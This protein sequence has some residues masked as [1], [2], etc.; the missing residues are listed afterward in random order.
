VL[1]HVVLVELVARAL[2]QWYLTV[3]VDLV[4]EV[5]S[6][7][8]PAYADSFDQFITCGRNGSEAGCSGIGR[9]TTKLG[10]EHLALIIDLQKKLRTRMH[11]AE[12]KSQRQLRLKKRDFWGGLYLLLGLEEPL[13]GTHAVDIFLRS[14][15]ALEYQVREIM[16]PQLCSPL[17]RV[18][19][20]VLN[21]GRSAGTTQAIKQWLAEKF[22]QAAPSFENLFLSVKFTLSVGCK[23]L[24]L[25][26]DMWWWH[27]DTAMSKAGVPQLSVEKIMTWIT[28]TDLFIGF[29]AGPIHIAGD[30]NIPVATVFG[31]TARIRRSFKGE[32][33]ENVRPNLDCSPCSNFSEAK[34]PSLTRDHDDRKNLSLEM[35]AQAAQCDFVSVEV[36]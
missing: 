24:E 22:A 29:Y 13:K 12:I 23:S 32:R 2:K 7:A 34:G 1:E 35:F 6:G 15:A 30:Y 3:S 18:E 11:A 26:F 27:V 31:P 5:Q 8:V 20:L 36:K 33:R 28:S 14:L 25:L 4:T 9:V 21:I 16:R 19:E 10:Q 17:S